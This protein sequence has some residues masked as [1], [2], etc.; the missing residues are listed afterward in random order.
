METLASRNGIS[1]F[2]K[3]LLLGVIDR[4]DTSMNRDIA[5]RLDGMLIG[6]AGNLDG[7]AHYMKN[8]LSNDEYS[9]LIKSIG[10]S[11]AALSDVSMSL[12]SE[13]PDIRPKEL[14]PPSA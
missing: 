3:Q 10:Q 13:F 7:I 5:I 9:N 1:S 11:M 8:N 6:V 4:K 14:E 12:Y 2:V